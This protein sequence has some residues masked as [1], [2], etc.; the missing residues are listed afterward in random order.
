L[1]KRGRNTVFGLLALALLAMLG[2]TRTARDEQPERNPA[3]SAGRAPKPPKPAKS[4][5]SSER[6]RVP[7][8][9]PSSLAQTPWASLDACRAALAASPNARPKGVA[10]IGAWN[11][12]WFPDGGPGQRASEDG[13]NLDWLACAIAWLQVDVLA[14]EEIKAGPRPRQAFEE[15]A[16]RLFALTGSRFVTLLDDCPKSSSQKLGLLWNEQRAALGKHAVLSELNPHGAPCKDQL[17]PGLAAHFRFPGGLD[18]TVVAAH[19]KSGGERRSYELRERSFR[20]FGAAA[21][22]ARALTGD[23]DVLFIGDMNTMGCPACSPAVTASDELLAVERV[24]QASNPPLRRLPSSPGCSHSYSGDK[25]LL[26]WA[27]AS[28]LTELPRGRAAAVSGYCASLGCDTNE[29]P[30]RSTL[31]LSDHCPVLV[32]VDDLDRDS[33]GG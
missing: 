11:L 24:L 27:L 10:R 32:D 14:V 17:R 5:P 4:R 23:A 18:L 9:V 29:R 30:P 31:A 15:L 22:S 2:G 16:R 6:A 7:D 20:A 26:D 28:D 8:P 25:T 12:H 19:L 1:T 13:A 33:Q 3:P 21:L